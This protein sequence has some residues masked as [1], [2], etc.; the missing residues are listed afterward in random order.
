MAVRSAKCHF[1]SEVNNSWSV[2]LQ[3]IDTVLIIVKKTWH[4]DASNINSDSMLE[5]SNGYFLHSSSLLQNDSIAALIWA[6]RQVGA[7]R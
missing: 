2:Q 7:D 1:V 6:L 3:E 5:M 4:V